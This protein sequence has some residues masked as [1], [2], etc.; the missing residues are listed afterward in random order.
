MTAKISGKRNGGYTKELAELVFTF[1]PELDNMTDAGL[2]L[3]LDDLVQAEV[4]RIFG[5]GNH[6]VFLT[7]TEQAFHIAWNIQV[8]GIVDG[9]N[10]ASSIIS[11]LSDYLYPGVVA[12]TLTDPYLRM[13]YGQDVVFVYKDEIL[14]WWINSF[15]EYLPQHSRMSNSFIKIM[16]RFTLLHEYRHCCQSKRLMRFS[17]SY[18]SELD[19]DE[20]ARQVIISQIFLEQDW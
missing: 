4:D 8:Q 12:T 1:T 7:T 13:V 11:K 20:Y 19:A 2:L 17:N 3:H 16:T 18:L 6:S 10:M 14:S 15:A 9:Y 5:V